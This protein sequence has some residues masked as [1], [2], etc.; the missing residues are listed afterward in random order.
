MAV[1]GAG[2][3]GSFFAHA[4]LR[5]SRSIGLPLSVD[6]Y[7]PRTHA[8]T[9]PGGCAHC[10]G[11]VSESLVQILATEGVRIPGRV[12]RR[13]IGSYVVHL[14]V[15]HVLIRSA[16]REDRIAALFRGDGPRGA[17]T[18]PGRSFDGHL[19]ER[20]VGDGAR[21]VRKLVTDVEREDGLRV[22]RHPD[23]SRSPGYH[24]V[25]VATGVNSRLAHLE[26]EPRAPE[27]SRT[28]ICELRAPE[29]V[30]EQ[31][32]GRSMHVFLLD[33]PRLEFAALIPKGDH[34]TLC[35]LGDG[36]DEELVTRFLESPE[37]R[38]CFP[39]GLA[40]V[41]CQCSPLINVRARTRPYRERVVF[42][43]D[44]GVT[45][46]YKDGIGAAFRTAK[47]AADTAV[48][49]GVGEEDF[50]RRYHPICRHIESDNRLGRL[51]FGCTEL[52]KRS[53]WARRAVLLMVRE[54]QAR[55]GGRRPMSNT[56]W[57]LFTGS[58]P[59]R[60]ILIDAL[61][62]S[63]FVGFGR[64]LVRATF[65]FWKEQPD[66]QPSGAPVS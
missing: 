59:Y 19:L 15:G 16:R 18:E 60:A 9:G 7:D 3:A 22:L 37:V 57:N 66:E 41:V 14:D 52:F 45:R 55:A 26:L 54:E 11:I 51:I 34:V 42:I 2:P 30:I 4:L 65:G 25:A 21:L 23:G 48:L 40:R 62:P 31:R 49:F 12:V 53:R 1:V 36:I 56:L 17:T 50:A 6:L 5:R 32:L 8:R 33:L 39:S 20:A 27:T 46:L 13:G 24:L 38:C 58:A 47:A 63:F 64:S 29:D 28:Y 61:H 43:G 44:A 35:M 10:G